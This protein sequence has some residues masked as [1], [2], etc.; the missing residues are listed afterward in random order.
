M[1]VASS[2]V[3]RKAGRAGSATRSGGGHDLTEHPERV[4]E[5]EGWTVHEVASV[6]STNLFA[7]NLPVWHAARA[8]VQTAGRG[9][10]QRIWISDKG[11]LWLSAVVP[12]PSRGADSPRVAREKAVSSAPPRAR[13]AQP[14][15]PLVA[16]LAV[17]DALAELGL[18][19]F[20]MRWPNDV[21]VRDRKLAGLLLDQF[22][23]ARV[24]VGVGLNVR[25]Q[26]EASDAALQ[27]QATRLSDWLPES[28]GL[29]EVAA[30]VL[31]HLRRLALEAS[32]KGFA[33]MHSR[34]NALWQGPRRV[35]LL[36]DVGSRP[37]LFTS[38]DQD[39]RL[40]LEDEAGR[41]TAYNPS[42]VHHLREI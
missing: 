39:G 21:L 3:V 28:P 20:R 41:T 38:V 25:N 31:R 4:F 36:L 13:P 17:C 6:D 7:A 34:V 8:E 24:V 26:P 23:R 10:F 15:L 2:P 11:G 22:T 5:L 33:A 42:Q 29:P 40:L 9:R 19:G 14:W 35:E 1:S 32:Q 12:S 30:V 27:N 16:G 18:T 37:G